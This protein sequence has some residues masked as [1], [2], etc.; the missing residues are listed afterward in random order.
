MNN[1]NNINNAAAKAAASKKKMMMAVAL[2]VFCCCVC[3]CISSVVSGGGLFFASKKKDEPTASPSAESPSDASP[4]AASPPAASPPVASKQYAILP[5]ETASKFNEEGKVWALAG[6]DVTCRQSKKNPLALSQFHLKSGSAGFEK[7][8][9]KYDYKCLAGVEKEHTI[10][11]FDSGGKHTNCDTHGDGNTVYLDRHNVDCGK[12][13]I[14]EFKGNRCMSTDKYRYKYRCGNH[15]SE[16]CRDVST[17]F[18]E[19]GSGNV[20]YLDRHDVKC[21]E[22][23]EY[24]SKFKLS[25]NGEGKY[26]Y[27]YTCCKP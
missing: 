10:S 9:I 23:E 15:K 19:E 18:N 27:D 4:P 26:R 1:A 25:R 20:V 22:G 16:N 3:C 17:N 11:G 21:K 24:I 13:P 12:S 8:T 6:L 2:L 7:N 14:L 5:Y